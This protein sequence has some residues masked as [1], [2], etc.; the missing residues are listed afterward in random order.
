MIYLKIQFRSSFCA[1]HSCEINW[2]KI[3][4]PYTNFKANSHVC[5]PLFHLSFNNTH[6]KTH[7]I[8]FGTQYSIILFE[9][10][11]DYRRLG[12]VSHC[13]T[14]FN[15]PLLQAVLNYTNLPVLLF[16]LKKHLKLTF[17]WL[18]ERSKHGATTICVSL[19]GQ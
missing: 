18:E 7:I 19:T 5:C 15:A 3:S 4:K 10:T 1:Q 8:K 17:R 13:P 11:R 2:F 14:F 12:L 6:P 9:Q 16:T